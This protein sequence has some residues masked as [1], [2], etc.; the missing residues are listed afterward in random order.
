[1]FSRADKEVLII[2]VLQA[3]PSYAISC[4]KLPI[5]LCK[6]FSNMIRRF[7]WGIPK[8]KKGICWKAWYFLCRPKDVGGLGFRDFEAFNQAM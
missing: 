8:D 5:G 3:I 2:S 7:W 1:M 6:D 4:F